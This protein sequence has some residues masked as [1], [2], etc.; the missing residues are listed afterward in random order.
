MDRDENTLYRV[1]IMSRIVS[2][3]LIC[4]DGQMLNGSDRWYCVHRCPQTSPGIL[5]YRKIRTHSLK[6]ITFKY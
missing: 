3:W 4:N 2:E 6:I 1:D 5:L